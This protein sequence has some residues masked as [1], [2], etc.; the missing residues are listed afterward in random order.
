MNKFNASKK[1]QRNV[2]KGSCTCLCNKCITCW[3][4]YQQRDKW[5]AKPVVTRSFRGSPSITLQVF[6]RW[7]EHRNFE[8]RTRAPFI[9]LHVQSEHWSSFQ[10]IPQLKIKCSMQLNTAMKLNTAKCDKSKTFSRTQPNVA[11]TQHTTGVLGQHWTLIK[12]PHSLT[13]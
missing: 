8:I 12:K 10:S 11:K 13:S 5:N 2:S 7:N 1:K 4:K 6:V 3:R 9:V